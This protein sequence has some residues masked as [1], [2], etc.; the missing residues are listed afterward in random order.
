MMTIARWGLVVLVAVG[1][2][3]V[4]DPVLAQADPTSFLSPGALQGHF[5]TAETLVI[6]GLNCAIAGGG[7]VLSGIF[8]ISSFNNP[9]LEWQAG[10]SGPHSDGT[11]LNGYLTNLVL[12]SGPNPVTFTGGKIV[13]YNVPFGTYNVNGGAVPAATSAGAAAFDAGGFAPFLCPVGGCPTPWLTL[14]F[15]PGIN[16]PSDT[17]TTLASVF[18]S[19]TN[20]AGSGYLTVTGGTDASFFHSQTFTFPGTGLSPADFLFTNDLFLCP[21]AGGPCGGAGAWPLAA[22]D[23]LTGVVAAVPE[24]H[25]LLLLGSGLLGLRLWRLRLRSNLGS[26]VTSNQSMT[27]PFIKLSASLHLNSGSPTGN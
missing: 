5:T 6:P 16:A 7:C 25:S 27:Q 9:G 17:A 22:Q 15:V 21:V 14:D 12:T 1:L 11:E 2:Y 20:G 3:L 26:A 8:H 24:P 13:I 4:Y 19:S 18:F 10:V 23:P